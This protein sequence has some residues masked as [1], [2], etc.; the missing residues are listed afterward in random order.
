M[1]T[2]ADI[3]GNAPT[4]RDRA[5][6]A[7]EE[8]RERIREKHQNEHD[9]LVEEMCAFF[10]QDLGVARIDLEDVEFQKMPRENDFPVTVCKVGGIWFRG[11]YTR[12]K[13]TIGHD[14]SYESNILRMQMTNSEKVFSNTGW[15]LVRNLAD[16]GKALA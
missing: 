4:L 12:E 5:K 16:L 7:F 14:H 8:E 1:T 15:L 9:I 6:A 13:T 3:L 11:S 10:T 2:V